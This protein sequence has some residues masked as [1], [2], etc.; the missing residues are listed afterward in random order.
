MTRGLPFPAIFSSSPTVLT[1]SR[2]GEEPVPLPPSNCVLESPTLVTGAPSSRSYQSLPTIPL[3]EGVA[4]RGLGAA[5]MGLLEGRG[6]RV[7]TV[8]DAAPLGGANGRT[9]W[10]TRSVLVRAEG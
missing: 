2:L 1:S 10:D 3:V 6:Y 7:D 4:P 9:T 8:P 5:V